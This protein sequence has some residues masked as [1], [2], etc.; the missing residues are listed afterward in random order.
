V[1]WQRHRAARR[2]AA[3][4]QLIDRLPAQRHPI[5][6]ARHQHACGVR[7]SMCGECGRCGGC[8]SSLTLRTSLRKCIGRCEMRRINRRRVGPPGEGV[9]SATAQGVVRRGMAAQSTARTRPRGIMR[10]RWCGCCT[11]KFPH[12]SST[13]TRSLPAS[14]CT[15]CPTYC[16]CPSVGLPL[17][18]AR[19]AVKGAAL[20]A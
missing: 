18:Y 15:Q 14:L 9:A 10:S 12:R 2:A 7:T 3:H 1:I 4:G 20:C 6:S 13:P 17:D 19:L 11:F 5:S 8:R 16:R